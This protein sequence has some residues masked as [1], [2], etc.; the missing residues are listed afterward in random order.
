MI[1]AYETAE[2]GKSYVTKCKTVSVNE[3]IISDSVVLIQQDY[4]ESSSCVAVLSIQRNIISS[5]V[6]SKSSK[7]P[8]GNID[9]TPSNQEPSRNSGDYHN[10]VS[11][12]TVS[13][14]L[15]NGRMGKPNESFE[16]P[17]PNVV[18]KQAEQQSDMNWKY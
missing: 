7:G 14:G 3:L 1:F 5:E 4:Y 15:C 11:N 12:V 8:T 2:S 17:G 9:G 16:D 18:V 10:S 6:N 13:V